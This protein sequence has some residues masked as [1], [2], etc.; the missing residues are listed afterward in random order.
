MKQQ[1]SNRSKII[2]GVISSV[3][4]IV[5]LLF[6]MFNSGIDSLMTISGWIVTPVQ[7]ACT[8]I[9]DAISG[10]FSGFG[11]NVELTKK[12]N[13][14]LVELDKYIIQDQ[15]YQDILQEN[16]QLR[17]IIGESARYSEFEFVIGR[18]SVSKT[19]T[20]VDNYTINKGSADGI[21]ENMVVVATGGL[22]GRIVEVSEHYSVMMTILDSRSSVPAIVER[23]RD[24]G[25]VKGNSVDGEVQ[26]QCTMTYLPFELKSMTGDIVKTSGADDVFPKGIHIGSIVEISTGDTTLGTTAKIMPDVDFEH[27]EYVLIITGGGLVERDGGQ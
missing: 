12:Y 15:K 10:F 23:T 18:V 11:D 21:K 22:A 8:A 7:N 4:T 25:V 16:A 17:E 2:I 6:L 9:G 20:Y 19:N 3:T 24:T 27:L 13:D 26:A 5:V 1:R 14:L